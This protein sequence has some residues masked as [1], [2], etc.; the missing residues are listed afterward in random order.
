MSNIIPWIDIE[1]TGLNPAIDSILQV[2]VITTN[3]NLE[4]I[5]RYDWIIKQ[6]NPKKIAEITDSVVMEIHT[7]TGLWERTLSPEAKP[8]S[9]VDKELAELLAEIKG[10]GKWGVKFAGNSV[11]FDKKFIQANM[12]KSKPLISHQVIDMS[13]VLQFMRVI[14][15]PVPLPRHSNDHNALNDIAW[16]LTQ[17]RMARGVIFGESP[18]TTAFTS[19][20]KSTES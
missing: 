18:R 10:D 5:A 16:C 7:E 15:K 11:D 12:P 4:E 13:A 8:L 2:A 14:G 20:R 17:A 1:T 6:D 3:H 19:L 9:T